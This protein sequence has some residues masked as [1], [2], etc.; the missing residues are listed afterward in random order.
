MLLCYY[1]KT[2]KKRI[3]TE[4]HFCRLHIGH[5]P[6]ILCIYWKRLNKIYILGKVYT[7]YTVHCANK[8]TYKQTNNKH[9]QLTKMSICSHLANRFCF[10]NRTS[11]SDMLICSTVWVCILIGAMIILCKNWPLGTRAKNYKWKFKYLKKIVDK[12]NPLAYEFLEWQTLFVWKVQWFH[13]P[14]MWFYGKI[15]SFNCLIEFSTV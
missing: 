9:T 4:M 2:E 1:S 3:W 11:L 6:N 8:L 7:V 14:L 10:E 15:Q 5:Q 13:F 12:L